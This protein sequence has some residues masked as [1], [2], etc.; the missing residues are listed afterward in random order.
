MSGKASLPA[1]RHR[2][3]YRE[4]REMSDGICRQ[5]AAL[6]KHIATED[7]DSLRILR[8]LD[9]AVEQAWAIA[10]VGLRKTGYSD[11]EIGEMLGVTRQAVQQRWPW[12]D[13]RE[14]MPQVV[15]R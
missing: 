5:V 9:H 12:T 8:A 1:R 6:G 2:R 3:R 7:V 10:I 11:R 14:Q 13:E 15:R 4:T